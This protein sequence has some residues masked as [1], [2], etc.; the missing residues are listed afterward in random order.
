MSTTWF[1]N[2]L[3][4]GWQ[5]K[6][7]KQKNN[8]QKVM[9]CTGPIDNVGAPSRRK[10]KDKNTTNNNDPINPWPTYQNLETSKLQIQYLQ[11][12]KHC[13]YQIS[14]SHRL[15]D[16]ILI[17]KCWV[18][19]WWSLWLSPSLSSSTDNQSFV[20]ALVGDWWVCLA[21]VV[22]LCCFDF[23]FDPLGVCLGAC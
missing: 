8:N 16:S 15:Y 12:K 4:I 5:E 1:S 7:S 19:Q 23:C 14:H 17:S 22:S 10:R 3:L 18:R 13:F 21:C 11:L 20:T 9:H 2:W 6:K